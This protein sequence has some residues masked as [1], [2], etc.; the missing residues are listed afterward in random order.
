MRSFLKSG[1]LVL[2]SICLAQVVHSQTKITGIVTDESTGESLIGANISVIGSDVGTITDFDGL[3]ELEV[4]SSESILKISY[5]GYQTQQITVGDRTN[6]D[7][8]M[9]SGELL[10]EV[11]VIGYGTVKRE[12][13][14]GSVQS[15]SSKSFNRG[16]IT[17]P[18]E[19]L[20]GKVAGV[21]ITPSADPGG[22]ARIRIRGESSLGSSNDP[23]IVIDGVP[24]ESDKTSG[25]RNPLNIINPN[26]IETFTVLKDA[27]A[28]A[29]YG[30]RASGGVIL[31]TTKKG[32][33]GQGIKVGYTGNFSVS[34]RLNSVD[35]LSADEFRTA[36]ENNYEEGHP[37]RAL[38][39]N[40]NTDWQDEIYQSATGTDHNINVSGGIGNI[41]YRVSLGYTNKNGILKTD[42]FK[43]YT[44]GINLNPK[45]LD[46]RLQV[47]LSLK[48]MQ[49]E[50]RF[51][52]RGAVGNA[53]GFDP[54]QEVFDEGNSFG[55]YTTW[56]IAGDT[57]GTT[58]NALAPT[59]PM[60]LLDL[61]RDKS[62]TTR[63]I[64]QASIDYRFSFL[65]AL[66]ANLNLAYDYGKGEGSV[67][68]PDFAAFAFDDIN[69][70]GVNNVY[71]HEKKNSLLEFYLNYKKDYGQH[72]LDLMG[73]YSW[74]KFENNSVFRNSDAANTI[75]E[76][77]EGED[78]YENYLVS[79]FGRA[80]YSF[81]N[82]FLA[83]FTLRNDGTSRFSPDSRWGL[84]PAAAIGVKLIENDNNRFNSLKLR[85]GWGVTGQ[86]DIGNSVKDFYIYQP[87]YQLG[88]ENAQY[89][90]G[91]Q[92]YTTYRPN[93]Y[94]ANLKW[95]ETT[96]YNIGLDYSIIKNRL[97]GTL[98][99]YRRET[100]DLLNVVSPPAGT[101]LT[102]RII[103]NVGNMESQGVEIA[104]NSTP[105]DR[106]NF[107]WDLSVNMSYNTNEITKLTEFDDPN[108]QG[109]EVGGIAGG[110]GS[111]IQI[112]S[113]GHAPYSF[114][115]FEQAYDE[116]GDIIPGEFVDQ[117]GDNEITQED[118]YRYKN[119]QADYSFGMNTNIQ[120][121][122]LDLSAAGRALI[123]NYA[124]SN[125][126]T[127][128]GYLA[129][130]YGSTDV[131]QNVHQSAI[132]NNAQNQGDL[133]FSDHFVRDASFF[134]LDHV[135]A[136]YNLKYLT[137][138]DSRISVT[139][140]NPLLIT[141]YDGIDP[142]FDNG[143]DNNIY[144]R[145]RTIVIGFSAN[146]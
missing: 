142:E 44:S 69:G 124:Y 14:T 20:A 135:T 75:S 93:G 119:P 56:T 40:A 115:V 125:V 3:F 19:L 30:N 83:T 57:L 2:F 141:G 47:N 143:I 129:R 128:I 92:Y 132:D 123:G 82:R 11:V 26:D 95:E 67:F 43:R 68:V 117:N 62:E 90:F 1:I 144:P 53:L 113:V 126:E 140:Q 96:T 46:N 103:S 131:T 99:V 116:N 111:N 130:L 84:F 9:A 87:I 112:H 122:N 36:I 127:D 72:S 31:I 137:N 118:R 28:T 55:G 104:L 4:P 76:T 7:I 78:L 74:Q 145:S 21:S 138:F 51:A 39:G 88:F 48:S 77:V 81:N 89:Q 85:A 100:I 59:N 38:L 16:A 80:N 52:D 49:I 50:N 24:I 12:D 5:T 101:N 10:E 139:I 105:V 60:A 136:G 121:G 71:S 15:V 106:K 66:R 22:G 146:F 102:N 63:Y 34:E 94:N 35:V 41:P 98:D 97:S 86:Q 33:L 23:L 110:V 58:P 17:G 25:S 91:N 133:T 120:I 6:I 29:I 70:G 65:P 45:F 107:I 79:F 32:A 73:G 114:Y 18:Q 54:T 61:K 109:I 108:Y 8:L 134:R 13:A 27:S 37:A 42:N 64:T